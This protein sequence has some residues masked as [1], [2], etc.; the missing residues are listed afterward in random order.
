MLHAA[1]CGVQVRLGDGV[2]DD[3]RDGLGLVEEGGLHLVVRPVAH[4]ALA[5]VH[6]EVDA[7]EARADVAREED[8]GRERLADDVAAEAL[9]VVDLGDGLEA[10]A[11]GDEVGAAGKTRGNRLASAPR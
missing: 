4:D 7:R 1:A 10:R 9:H 2:E 5:V 11:V 3:R 6:D 8:L